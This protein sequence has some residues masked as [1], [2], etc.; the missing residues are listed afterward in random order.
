MTTW[1]SGNSKNGSRNYHSKDYVMRVRTF[2]EAVVNYIGAQK[3]NIIGH[4]MGVTL[5]RKAVKGG[6][7]SDH[8]L[9]QYNVGPSLKNRVNVFIGLAGA[10]L[11]LTACSTAT[12]IP[13]C[14]TDD[15]FFP[16]PTP[17]STPSIFLTELNRN[18]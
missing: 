12:V 18:V 7:A 10:N 14:N 11:G 13:T 17:M 9:H 4:S 16:G 1:G 15:V 2:I 6:T 8:V 3:I 5:A